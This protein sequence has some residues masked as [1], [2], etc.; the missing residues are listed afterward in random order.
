[1]ALAGENGAGKTTLVRCISGDMVA[2]DGDILLDGRPV[3]SDP[4]AVLR[5]GVAVVW[6]ELVTGL[7]LQGTTT[8]WSPTHPGLRHVPRPSAAA[9][10]GRLVAAELRP[11]RARRRHR[12]G[13]RGR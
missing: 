11:G 10:A 5:R 3:P 1:V 13:G 4:G 2:D 9:A 7:R 12:R 6:Q 8:C